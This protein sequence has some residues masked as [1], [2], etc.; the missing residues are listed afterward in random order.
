MRLYIWTNV[1]YDYT[2]GMVVTYANSIE[3]S[4]ALCL[5]EFPGDEREFRDLRNVSEGAEVVGITE[6]C[7]VDFVYGG[8]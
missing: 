5:A 1:L 2:S 8:G 6:P 3:E 4:R 7:I